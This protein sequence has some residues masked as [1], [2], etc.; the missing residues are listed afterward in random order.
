L[1]LKISNEKRGDPSHIKNTSRPAMKFLP[2]DQKKP[3]EENPKLSN[4]PEKE[5]SFE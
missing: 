5:I 3:K 1:E 4:F 2:D